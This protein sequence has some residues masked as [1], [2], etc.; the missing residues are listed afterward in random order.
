MQSLSCLISQ[1]KFSN[2]INAT[3][4]LIFTEIK[5]KNLVLDPVYLNLEFVIHI[6]LHVTKIHIGLQKLFFHAS[7]SLFNSPLWHI[8]LLSYSEISGQVNVSVSARDNYCIEVVL[9]CMA[10]AGD[11]IGPHELND[12]G[13]LGTI[14][15]AGFKGMW[16]NHSYSFSKA[17]TRVAEWWNIVFD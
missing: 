7:A 9:R 3:L 13:T 17:H 6:N 10:V 4:H 8:C 14:M 12:G 11:G 5:P 16:D 1:M 15:A 2:L